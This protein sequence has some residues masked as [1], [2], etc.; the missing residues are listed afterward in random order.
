MS[1]LVTGAAGFIGFHTAQRLLERGK[2]VIGVDNLNDYYDVGLKRARLDRLQSPGCTFVE[3]DISDPAIVEELAGL[4]ADTTVFIHL[5]AQA[6]V[7]YSLVNPYAYVGSNLMGQVAML[8]LAKR[9]PRLEHFVYASS[10]SVYGGNEKL[11]FSVGDDVMRP[12]SLYAATKL[13]DEVITSTYCHLFGLAATGLRFFTVY[14]AWGRPDMAYFTFTKAILEDRPIPI[15]NHGEMRRDFSYIDDVVDGILAAAERPPAPDETGRRHR[16]YNLGNNRSE[17]LLDFVAVLERALGKKAKL[18]LQPMQ[19][20]D[21]PATW[22]DIEDS[23]HDLGY[24][25]KTPIHV[26]LPKF[27]DWY[28]SYYRI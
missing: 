10:S 27:V 22:A 20:G 28:K 4:A 23:R 3:R 8:E 5:A 2:R 14:G 7:R 9:L 19:P 13:A 15:F 21:V 25:P 1:V 18:E 17:R 16:V 24:D 26:G 11:P 6:G 12:V